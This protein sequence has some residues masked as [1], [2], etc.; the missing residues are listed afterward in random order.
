MIDSRGAG[1]GVDSSS[2]LVGN[3]G[4][5]GR[6][7][8]NSR[9]VLSEEH[10]ALYDAELASSTLVEQS[11]EW[12][13]AVDVCFLGHHLEEEL[14]QRGFTERR[15]GMSKRAGTS[16]RKSLGLCVV[17]GWMLPNEENLCSMGSRCLGWEE[18]VL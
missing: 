2:W 12:E 13:P 11:V 17:G 1:V 9:A 14:L 4:E 5:A 7:R 6:D 3:K 16:G 8:L 10:L 15:F 18:V